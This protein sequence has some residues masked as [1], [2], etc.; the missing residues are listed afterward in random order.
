LRK[1]ELSDIIGYSW[2]RRKNYCEKLASFGKK[3]IPANRAG[4]GKAHYM[5]DKA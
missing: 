4:E 1:N 2:N 3:Y 5:A